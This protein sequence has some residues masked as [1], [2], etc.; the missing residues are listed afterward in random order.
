MSDKP[1]FWTPKR[2]EIVKI[3]T[4]TKSPFLPFPFFIDFENKP[5]TLEE[6]QAYWPE[7]YPV[8]GE[9]KK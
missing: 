9:K 7:K 8:E 1:K 3:K 6:K 5:M 4:L 2:G